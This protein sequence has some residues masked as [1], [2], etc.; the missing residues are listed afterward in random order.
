MSVMRG[1]VAASGIPRIARRRGVLVAAVLVVMVPFIAAAP[2]G[3][4]MDRASHR[5]GMSTGFEVLLHNLTLGLLMVVGG[6]LT[7]GLGTVVL[8]LVGSI[9]SGYVVGAL[10][11]TQG[12]QEAAVLLPHFVPEMAAFVAFAGAGI[13]GAVAASDLVLRRPEWLVARVVDA[14]SLTALGTAL[15]V[16]G[17]VVEA[18]VL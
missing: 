7:V 16:L 17:A 10:I 14:C 6:W 4:L 18:T 3:A 15:I 9:A 2:I 1:Q 5:P 13:H 12:W 11:A 8:A